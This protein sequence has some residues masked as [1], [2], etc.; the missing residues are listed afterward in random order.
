MVSILP[1]IQFQYSTVVLCFFLSMEG[2]IPWMFIQIMWEFSICFLPHTKLIFPCMQ[3]N[4]SYVIFLF[5][6]KLIFPCMQGDLK[7]SNTRNIFFGCKWKFTLQTKP[8]RGFAT[9]YFQ[10]HHFLVS[11]LNQSLEGGMNSFTLQKATIFFTWF[12][13]WFTAFFYR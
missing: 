1:C 13:S 6:T 11:W 3:G 10:E 2:N 7:K 9:V 4:F 8:V 5:Y 12:L